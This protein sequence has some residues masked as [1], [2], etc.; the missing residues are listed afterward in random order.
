MYVL[1]WKYVDVCINLKKHI[2]DLEEYVH[3][4]WRIWRID[5]DE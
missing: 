4:V 2:F 5:G 1:I 3:M